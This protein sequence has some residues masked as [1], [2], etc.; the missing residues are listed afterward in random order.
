MQFL[1]PWV[2]STKFMLFVLDHKNKKF[3]WIDPTSTP[4]WCK[5][6]PYKKYVRAI[7][8][9]SIKYMSAMRVYDQKWSQN[10]FTWKA[11]SADG[12]VEDKEG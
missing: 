12:I 4:E 2:K 7:L 11:R 3:T 1:M 8:D 10:I 6:M 9:M 5:D